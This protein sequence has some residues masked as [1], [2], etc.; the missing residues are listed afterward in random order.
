MVLLDRL[1]EEESAGV[2]FNFLAHSGQHMHQVAGFHQQH[3]QFGEPF[4]RELPQT[5]LKRLHGGFRAQSRAGVRAPAEIVDI[6]GTLHEMRLFKDAHEI[7]L[8]RHAGRINSAAHVRA[9]RA[10]KPGLVEYEIEAELLHEFRRSGSQ[11][12]AY[13]SIVAGGANACVLHYNDNNQ[14]LRN[15]ELLLIDELGP[16]EFRGEGGFIA[17]FAAIDARHY[18]LAVVV[19]RPE[20]LD[21]ARQRWPWYSAVAEMRMP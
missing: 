16:L 12:P 14:L 6:R 18:R 19:V 10:T 4:A 5:R 7:A 3:A 1:A 20:L 17:G 9:M 21:A 15:G 11:F 13:T 2:V 8:L